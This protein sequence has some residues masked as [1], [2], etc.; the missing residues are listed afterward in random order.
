VCGELLI[1]GKSVI[2]HTQVTPT[3][4]HS[5]IRLIE[6]PGFVR[7]LEMTAQPLLRKAEF[8][9]IVLNEVRVR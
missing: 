2:R 3:A 9:A 8:N 7:R 4:L 1:L 6:T 5:N